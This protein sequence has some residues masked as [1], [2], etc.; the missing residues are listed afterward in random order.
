MANTKSTYKELEAQAIGY[1]DF[2]D[3][4]QNFDDLAEGKGE[5]RELRA[6][7]RV[8]ISDY[9]EYLESD[10]YNQ[11][12]FDQQIEQYNAINDLITDLRLIAVRISIKVRILEKQKQQEERQAQRDVETP[13]QKEDRTQRQWSA[14]ASRSQTS[15]VRLGGQR[16]KPSAGVTDEKVSSV[17]EQNLGKLVEAFR[18]NITSKKNQPRGHFA[19]ARRLMDEYREV[20]NV[21]A[22]TRGHFSPMTIVKHKRAK[23]KMQKLEKNLLGRMGLGEQIEILRSDAR[24]ALHGKGEYKPDQIVHRAKEMVS[25]LQEAISQGEFVRPGHVKKQTAYLRD[26]V[27][28]AMHDVQS[29]A[30]DLSPKAQVDAK[31]KGLAKWA[32]Q[33]REG[34]QARRDN[35]A[36]KVEEEESEKFEVEFDDSYDDESTEDTENRGDYSSPKR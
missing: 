1:L 18:E 20:V 34:I 7:R 2:F 19:E 14:K 27:L 33:A 35:A 32:E 26:I 12:P 11:L 15:S 4:A 25:Q 31:P 24:E 30:D 8:L 29:I 17:A 28:S 22:R 21:H 36:F 23:H 6:A 3:G 13:S 10:E 5:L 9:D 16:A